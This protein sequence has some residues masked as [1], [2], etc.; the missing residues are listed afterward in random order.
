MGGGGRVNRKNNDTPNQI[1]N[2]KGK[3]RFLLDRNPTQNQINSTPPP[4]R[5]AKMR[6]FESDQIE[7]CMF[8]DVCGWANNF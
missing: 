5:E 1:E 8:A 2:E 6:L 7:D 3:E 4:Q